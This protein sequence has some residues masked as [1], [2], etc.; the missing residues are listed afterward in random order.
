MST[1]AQT[2]IKFAALAE[3]FGLE[4][5]KRKS[6]LVGV[7]LLAG[8]PRYV[9]GPKKG[10]PKGFITWIKTIRGGYDYAHGGGVRRPGESYGYKLAED[11]DD[12]ILYSDRCVRLSTHAEQL[13]RAQLRLAKVDAMVKESE[14]TVEGWAFSIERGEARSCLMVEDMRRLKAEAENILAREMAERAEA[15]QW[16]ADLLAYEGAQDA[17]S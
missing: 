4:L 2:Q 17:N 10:K 14:A 8:L 6:G 9:R 3:D 7:E 16:V 15:A 11:F 12:A 5:F 1:A 13:E